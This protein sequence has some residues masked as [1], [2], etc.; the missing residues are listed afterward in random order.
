MSVSFTC[1]ASGNFNASSTWSYSGGTPTNPYPSQTSDSATIGNGYTVTVGATDASTVGTLTQNG[2]GTLTVYGA[3]TVG[4]NSY[5]Y[6][7]A[8]S[9]VLNIMQGGTFYSYGGCA[10]FNGTLNM[11]SDSTG[12]AT[13][14]MTGNGTPWRGSSTSNFYAT[15]TAGYLCQLI[16]VGSNTSINF[17]WNNVW[18]NYCAFSGNWQF[19]FT[20]QNVASFSIQNSTISGYSQQF[21]VGDI[22][23]TQTLLLN[24]NIFSGTTYTYALYPGSGT[25]ATYP[26]TGSRIISNNSFDKP[27]HLG[28]GLGLQIGPNNY[29]VGNSTYPPI[30]FNSGQ[31]CYYDISGNLIYITGN[32]S[33]QANSFCLSGLLSNNL[34]VVDQVGNTDPNWF[35]LSTAS[36]SMH[37]SAITLSSAASASAS[38]TSLAISACPTNI[39]SGTTLYFGTQT[40]TVNYSAGYAATG[41]SITIT[42]S[43][44]PTAVAAGTIITFKNGQAT[45]STSASS[46]A[47]SLTLNLLSMALANSEAFY[48]GTIP[49]VTT[50]AVAGGATSIPVASIPAAIASGTTT[51]PYFGVG[52]IFQANIG[53]TNSA[54]YLWENSS[55]TPPT[56]CSVS[57]TNNIVLRQLNSSLVGSSGTLVDYAN[58]SGSTYYNGYIHSVINHNTASIDYSGSG[59]F[60]GMLCLGDDLGSPYPAIVTSFQANIAHAIN[61]HGTPSVLIYGIAT[62]VTGNDEVLPASCGYNATFNATASTSNAN[63]TKPGYYFPGTYGFSTTP[64]ASSTDVTLSADPFKDSSRDLNTAYTAGWGAGQ[65]TQGSAAANMQALCK[66]NG[67]SFGSTGTMSWLQANPGQIPRIYN[68]IRNGFAPTNMALNV[69]FSGDTNSVTNIGA[70]LGSYNYHFYSMMGVGS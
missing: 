66:P 70:V 7:T 60:I 21:W 44:L 4:N 5:N 6:Q 12:I 25:L 41:S 56:D 31:G 32:G 48:Y 57:I 42:V 49:V 10:Y 15:G 28:Q 63:T 23:A 68:A 47:T 27:I 52:N 20:N 65:T 50:S 33:G 36:T 45:V 38:P 34:I 69:T 29:L 43:A 53:S 37:P 67:G 64:L 51:L 8:A 54:I 18:C 16:G 1:I 26:T 55:N 24:G 35:Y 9:S 17:T 59:T 62:Y 58:P 2:T 46:G 30:T 13:L 3:I 19:N 22:T 14:Q 11:Y 61:G 40:A 39:P